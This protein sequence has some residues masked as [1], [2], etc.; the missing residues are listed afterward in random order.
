M[1]FLL[2]I[3]IILAMFVNSISAQ[4]KT[5][6]ADQ[7]YTVK[8]GAADTISGAS[9]TNTYTIYINNFCDVFKIGVK[10]TKISGTRTEGHYTISGSLDNS[11]YTTLETLNL[12][13]S[14]TVTRY[15]ESSKLTP[16][17]PYIKVVATGGDSTG[18]HKIQY[19]ILVKKN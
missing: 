4:D 9:G 19:Y 1:K 11:N 14:A 2:S 6:T 17:Y 15:V 5:I 10:Q 8:G 13:G 7:V 16:F 12:H 18:N 3:L